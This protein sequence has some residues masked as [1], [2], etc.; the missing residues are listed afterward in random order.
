MSRPDTWIVARTG[1]KAGYRSQ[2]FTDH[3]DALPSMMALVGV[4]VFWVIGAVGGISYLH[5]ASSP[6]AMLIGLYVMLG[7][8]AVSIIIATLGITDLT[9]RFSRQRIRR[10]I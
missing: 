2:W 6:M 10:Q 7:A 8:V 3:R 5:A 4:A 1:F 9:R